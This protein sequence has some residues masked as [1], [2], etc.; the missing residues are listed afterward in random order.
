MLGIDGNRLRTLLFHGGR[1]AGE[2]R[3]NNPSNQETYSPQIQDESPLISPTLEQIRCNQY[4]QVR[5]EVSISYVTWL[6]SVY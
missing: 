4:G 2:R 6:I 3:H 1:L 5:K